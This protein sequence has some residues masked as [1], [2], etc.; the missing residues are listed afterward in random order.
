MIY[1]ASSVCL[2]SILLVEREGDIV[3]PGGDRTTGVLAGGQ[4]R[5]LTPGY[6]CR[7]KLRDGFLV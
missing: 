3:F 1:A 6:I 4:T 7:A 5:L 2:P